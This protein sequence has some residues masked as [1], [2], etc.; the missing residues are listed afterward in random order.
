MKTLHTQLGQG[1]RDLWMGATGTGK[2]AL[3]LLIAEKCPDAHF[4]IVDADTNARVE[5]LARVEFP[6]VWARGQVTVERID[7]EDFEEWD[8]VIKDHAPKIGAD[9]WFV[10]DGFDLW[11]ATQ[12]YDQMRNFGRTRDEYYDA[13]ASSKDTGKDRDWKWMKALYRRVMKPLA[14]VEGHVVLTTQTQDFREKGDNALRTTYGSRGI[15]YRHRG[16]GELAEWPVK[17]LVMEKT[18]GGEIAYTTVKG[19][20]GAATAWDR[21]VIARERIAHRY[22]LELARFKYADINDDEKEEGAA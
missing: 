5:R 21:E 15:Q 11:S 8:Q 6:D 12:D 4:T 20:G 16:H 19:L 1:E 14:K 18:R 22:L 3:A 9:D 2:S 10:L 17:L 7:G 13:L